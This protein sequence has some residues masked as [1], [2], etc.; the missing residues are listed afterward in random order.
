MKRFLSLCLALML[1]LSALSSASAAKMA[2]AFE[3]EYFRIFIPGDWVI[4]LSSV[5]DYWGALDLGF[6]Y[7]GDKTMLMETGLY[8]YS[9]WSQD[10]LWSASDELWDE[11]VLFVTDDLKEEDPQVL[12]KIQAGEYPGILLRGT[13]DYGAYLYGEFLIN[14]YAYSFYFYLLNED[15]TVNSDITEEEVE[16]FR[17]IL[18]TFQPKKL[19]Q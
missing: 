4:D 9:D 11:Y 10:S 15:D 2:R 6:A 19:T 14:A 5:E 16:L 18:E 1:S 17:S 7:S 12:G 8:F 3:N 13:N